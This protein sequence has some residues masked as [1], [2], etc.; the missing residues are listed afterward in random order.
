[1]YRE[2]EISYNTCDVNILLIEP[3][4]DMKVKV[5]ESEP[6]VTTLILSST[7]TEYWTEASSI[8]TSMPM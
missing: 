5:E 8:Q 7:M 6:N 2:R 4:G 1:M 3:Q